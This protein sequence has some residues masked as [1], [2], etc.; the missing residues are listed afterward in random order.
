MTRQEFVDGVE[1]WSDLVDFCNQEGCSICEDVYSD[2]DRDYDIEEELC[3]MVRDSNWR[4]VLDTLQAYDRDSGYDYYLKN[5]CGEF[6]GL[7]DE[8]FTSYK[9]DVLDWGDNNDIW[10]DD[11]EDDDEEE[12][13]QPYD[14][15]DEVPLED[16]SFEELFCVKGVI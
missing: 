5:G 2:G 8:D 10:D 14:T 16:I 12:G 3:E 13:S 7:N 15:E 6:E 4:E 11:E 9:D 1:Y